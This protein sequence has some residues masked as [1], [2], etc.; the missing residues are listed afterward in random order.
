MSAT[1]SSPR[2]LDSRN[3]TL[4]FAVSVV[5]A[6]LLSVLIVGAFV[7]LVFWQWPVVQG[8]TNVLGQCAVLVAAF[9]GATQLGRHDQ[10]PTLGRRWCDLGFGFAVLM[11]GFG[12]LL[13]DGVPSIARA[14]ATLRAESAQRKAAKEAD[15]QVVP[16][17]GSAGEVT[18]TAPPDPAKDPG[19]TTLTRPA[20]TPHQP[21]GS[22]NP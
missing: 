14:I 13:R 10:P 4:A 16:A 21:A 8:V 1:S 5:A 18:A 9:Y 15:A 11:V 19:A 3:A 6:T 12:L 2:T 20:E 17:G 7:R 22:S